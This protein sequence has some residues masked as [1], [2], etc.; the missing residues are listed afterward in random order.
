[1]SEKNYDDI[2]DL[3]HYVSKKRPQ[4]SRRDRAA[5]FSPFAALTGYE[6]AVEE[7]ARLTDS[8]LVLTDE[9][10]AR[11]DTAMN[12]ILENIGDSPEI[13]VKFFVKDKLKCDGKYETH[14]G[15][16]RTFNEYERKLI[17]QDGAEIPLN[18]IYDIKIKDINW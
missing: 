4:M 10:A 12:I 14:R 13:S 7:T 16:I 11:L 8:R 18:D 6:D 1:M 17:F 5:Q 3:P 9:Q 15:N 2:I